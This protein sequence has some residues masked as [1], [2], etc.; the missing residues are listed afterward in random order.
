V[1][2][3]PDAGN[4]LDSENL[5]DLREEVY[6]AIQSFNSNN[7]DDDEQAERIDGEDFSEEDSND[8]EGSDSGDVDDDDAMDL[9]TME[10]TIGIE[11][12]ICAQY[13]ELTYPLHLR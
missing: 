13:A 2:D 11:I 7:E 3:A 1:P 10:K 4:E 5:S 6:Q 8:E 12:P 9:E